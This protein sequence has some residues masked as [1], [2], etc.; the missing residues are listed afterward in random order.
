MK[1]PPQF[2]QWW[3]VEA[4]AGRDAILGALPWRR[5]L[6]FCLPALLVAA[7]LRGWLFYEV[8]SAFIN[9][10]VRTIISSSDELVATGNLDINS[11][12][13]FLSPI[14]YAI[15][16]A[17]RLPLLPSI[18]FAQH[19]AGIAMVFFIGVLCA[20]WMKH[21]RW[22]IVPLTLLVAVD[23]FLLLYEHVA[24]PDYLYAFFVVTTLVTASFFWRSPNATT[25]ALLLLSLFLQ[26]GARQE[27]R[28][29]C[30]IALALV[31][32]AWWRTPR[33]MA[34]A[35]LV[36]LG[37]TALTFKLTV[38]GQS[39]QMLL[40][41]LLQLVPEESKVAP[42]L[43][44]R[45][46]ALQ[47]EA[48]ERWT[49]YPD[50]HNSTRTKIR[51]IVEKYLREER[52][53]DDDSDKFVDGFCKRVGIEAARQ[54]PPRVVTIGVRKFLATHDELPS[55]PIGLKEH[56]Q[57]QIHIFFPQKREPDFDEEDEAR[58]GRLMTVMFG[59]D[60]DTESA[61]KEHLDERYSFAPVEKLLA[62]ERRF[63][64]AALA[65]RL[66]DRTSAN[67][68]LIGL[69]W[70][71]IAG[72]AGVF[73]LAVARPR[74][75]GVI[76]VSVLVIGAVGMMVFTGANVRA[77]YRI[78]FEA[79]WFVGIFALLDALWIFVQ[80]IFQKAGAPKSAE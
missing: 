50:K 8:P 37:F 20:L 63:F 13:T 65:F 33:R 21:W 68:E 3:R 46:A 70:L 40:T 71:Y 14:L 26:A 72:L 41:S 12:R 74:W 39:G 6:L 58:M 32:L 53:I 56:N 77:R 49:L 2:T 10:D 28:F 38:T 1:L 11:K 54:D 16:L 7:A 78:G 31:V 61:L 27:G 73:A 60:F 15:P 64:N 57:R 76:F 25:L 36:T 42:G 17:L 52:G 67:Q 24:L 66:P 35:L 62:W 80:N 29:Y 59:R 75:R 30:A 44:R 55:A 43:P 18:A 48:N 69:P 47:A 22:W 5:V 34:I 79:I 23:P 9:S 19:A 4:A 51:K 45:L